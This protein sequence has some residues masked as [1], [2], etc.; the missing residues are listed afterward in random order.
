MQFNSIAMC[1][2]VSMYMYT[3]TVVCLVQQEP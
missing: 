3:L 1:D 2:N